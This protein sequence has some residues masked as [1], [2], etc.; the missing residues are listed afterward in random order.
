MLRS[1]FQARATTPIFGGVRTYVTWQQTEVM[2]KAIRNATIE[3]NT[4]TNT[5][6]PMI[7]AEERQRLRSDPLLSHLV[8]MVMRDGKKMQA[9]RFVQMALRD[10]RETSNSDPYKLLSDAI[11]IVSPLMDTKSARQGSKVIQVPRALNLRQ[12]RRRAFVWLL[13][14]VAK[15]NER[16]LHMRLSGELQAIVNGTSGIL[17]KKL[18]LHKMVLANRS[19]IR[20]ARSLI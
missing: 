16:E 6:S 12:R 4:R 9:E 11:E 18:A 1:L 14:S 20:T 10:I 15:R 19:N 8:N 17:E 3:T 7:S 13:A 5:P 2:K